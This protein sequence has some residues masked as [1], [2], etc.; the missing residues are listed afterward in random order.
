MMATSIKQD[1]LHVCN[2]IECKHWS[3]R[4]AWETCIKTYL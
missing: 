1:G 4:R 3:S 2:F